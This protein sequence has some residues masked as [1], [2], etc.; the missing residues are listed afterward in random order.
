MNNAS[1]VSRSPQLTGQRFLDG[2]ADDETQFAALMN[3]GAR[4][5]QTWKLRPGIALSAE[6][7]AALTTDIVWLVSTPRHPR[8]W[9]RHAGTRAAGLCRRSRR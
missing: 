7:M 1:Y 5:A 8:R 6:Q 4:F 3:A 9:H 2:Y